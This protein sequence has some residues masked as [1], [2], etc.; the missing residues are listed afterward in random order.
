MWIRNFSLILSDAAEMKNL[1]MGKLLAELNVQSA[2]LQHRTS[3]YIVQCN[4]NRAMYV[5]F[6]SGKQV[7]EQV[8]MT[9]IVDPKASCR[10]DVLLKKFLL[11]ITFFRY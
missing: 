2:I 8:S 11:G 4:H 9:R 10:N 5:I 3:N 1:F 7:L 6:Y